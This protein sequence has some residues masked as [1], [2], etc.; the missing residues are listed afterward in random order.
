M[1]TS[2]PPPTP[3][4]PP[5]HYMTHCKVLHHF[6]KFFVTIMAYPIKF[7]FLS[8]RSFSRCRSINFIN[9]W[10]VFSPA[11]LLVFACAGTGDDIALD[12]G[13]VTLHEIP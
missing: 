3:K 5:P 2:N 1:L 12:I 13:T 9:V 4:K 6:L 10:G 7:Y 8:Y 11:R